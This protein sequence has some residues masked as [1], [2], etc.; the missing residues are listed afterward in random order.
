MFASA[1][2]LLGMVRA[3][4]APACHIRQR[5]AFGL[6]PGANKEA[7]N[8]KRRRNTHDLNWYMSPYAR[9][10]FNYILGDMHSGANAAG[11]GNYQVAG[12]ASRFSMSDSASPIA[13]TF[14]TTTIDDCGGS[15]VVDKRIR[16]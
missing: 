13:E 16:T 10:Q 15:H 1:V 2:Q 3:W 9:M 4:R 8:S 14:S 11:Q 7:Q 5:I 6:R 12:L